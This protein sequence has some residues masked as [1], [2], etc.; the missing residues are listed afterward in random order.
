MQE[1]IAPSFDAKAFRAALGTF[2]TGVTVITA[3]G[4]NGEPIGLTANSFNS[5]S[6]DPPL[7]LWSLARKAFSLQDFVAARHWAVHVLSAEQEGISN[8]FA[9]G[10]QDKFAGV[11]CV[12][13]E[14]GVPLLQRCAARFE[15]TTTFQYEGGDHII[16]VGE[17][18]QFEKNAHPPLVFHAGKYALAACKDVALHLSQPAGTEP[19]SFR[20]DM[21]GYMFGRARRNFLDSMRGH[22]A[23]HGLSDYEWRLLTIMLTK[24]NL[25]ST[26]FGQF[27]QDAALDT[28]LQTLAALKDK[29][30]VTTVEHTAGEEPVYCL[31][32]KGVFDSV[33]LLAIAKSHE[34]Q[35]LGKMDD[36]DGVLLKHLLHKFIQKTEGGSPN[37]WSDEFILKESVDS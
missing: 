21:L 37:L 3:V 8:Q 23:K 16:F 28:I 29:G 10:G 31:T 30:W 14:H 7:V 34:E 13:S 32:D 12:P 15:C 17:V 18:T 26:M 33:S 25:T 11:A 4:R 5:V 35:L 19:P 1:T 22:L 36:M 27:N 20:A 2:A 6:L 24:K 9:R